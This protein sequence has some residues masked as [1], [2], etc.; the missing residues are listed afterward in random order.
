LTSDWRGIGRR[1]EDEFTIFIVARGAIL[2][3]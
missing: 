1:G 2:P 3:G